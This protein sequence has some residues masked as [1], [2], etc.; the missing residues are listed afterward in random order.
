MKMALFIIALLLMPITAFVFGQP[1]L[2]A[3]FVV[4]YICF[5]IIEVIA[6]AKSGKTVSGHVWELPMWKRLLVIASMIIGW[7]SLILHFLRILK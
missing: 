2:G 6:K 5:G 1:W 3:T 4:F 7:S